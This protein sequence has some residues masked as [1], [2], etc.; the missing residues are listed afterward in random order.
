MGFGL[1]FT[2]TLFF[3]NFN[4]GIVDFLP[5]IIGCLF[6]IAGLDKLRDLDGRFEYA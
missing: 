3:L 4:V 1:I 6:I 2:G 5:D